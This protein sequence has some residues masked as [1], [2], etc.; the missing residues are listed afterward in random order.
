MNAYFKEEFPLIT[1]IKKEHIREYFQIYSHG[2]NSLALEDAHRILFVMDADY[3][4]LGYSFEL[5]LDDISNFS[6]MN[7]GQ[8][9]VEEAIEFVATMQ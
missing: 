6:L 9:H 1:D 5:F 8:M 4:S 2:S 7:E 3:R